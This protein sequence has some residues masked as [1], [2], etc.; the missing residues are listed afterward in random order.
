MFFFLIFF[1]YIYMYID[2]G[3]YSMTLWFGGLL[4]TVAATCQ[5]RNAGETPGFWPFWLEGCLERHRRG[6]HGPGAKGGGGRCWKVNE[7]GGVEGSSKFVCLQ[8]WF[9]GIHFHNIFGG[10]IVW[11]ILVLFGVLNWIHSFGECPF[12]HFTDD[13]DAGGKNRKSSPK[14]WKNGA[15]SKGPG[16]IFCCCVKKHVFCF[17][18][19]LGSTPGVPGFQRINHGWNI[20]QTLWKDR[21]SQLLSHYTPEN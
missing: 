13:A 7:V 19:C 17:L 12:F 11:D 5:A 9:S 3:T 21:E 18:L 8:F 2:S 15:R 14:S 4:G 10:V 16:G 1:S 6:T 20:L